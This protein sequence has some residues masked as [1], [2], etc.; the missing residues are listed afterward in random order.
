MS[1][2]RNTL[3]ALGS[4]VA[5]ALGTGGVAQ[6][7][8]GADDPAGHNAGDDHGGLVAKA[9]RH[10]ADD[11]PG[12]DRGGRRHRA[13]HAHHARHGADDGPRHDANDDHGGRRR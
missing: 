4:V 13:R 6:A 11:G 5:L 10:G 9:A 12:D 8:H 2:R 7:K 3:V 1:T